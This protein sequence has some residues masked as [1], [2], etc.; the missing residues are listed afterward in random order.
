MC[1]R[2]CEYLDYIKSRD[3]PFYG[4]VLELL[5]GSDENREPSAPNPTLPKPTSNGDNLYPDI[6][7][8]IDD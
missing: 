8:K 4:E 6:K 7:K 1:L 5:A 2:E 3:V